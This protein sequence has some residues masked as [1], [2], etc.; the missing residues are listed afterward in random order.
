MQVKVS[1]QV[2]PWGNEGGASPFS[3]AVDQKNLI[4]IFTQRGSGL[5]FF[6]YKYEF[7]DGNIGCSAGAV[8]AIDLK[9]GY[10]IWEW[11]HP[12][13]NLN[14]DCF[15]DCLGDG[16]TDCMDYA[17][18]EF[19]WG[20]C[21][22]GFDGDDMLDAS[23]T[24]INVVYPPK[25]EDGVIYEIRRG[26]MIGPSTI[27]KNMVFIPTM[28]GEIY[29]HSILDGSYIHTIYC[30]EYEFE[31]KDENGQI[32]YTPNREGTRSGQT[33]FDDYLIF[34]CGA[35]FVHPTDKDAT[36]N[37]LLQKGDLVVM[38]LENEYSSD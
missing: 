24:S 26:S 5:D 33:M 30:P 7:S 10:T 38:K 25:N 22:M 8:F 17:H 20:Q 36:D 37:T 21:E 11:V 1:K 32:L 13:M 16:I 31:Y 12:W 2:A 18:F 14:D 28:T 3:L 15:F 35:T 9:T 4:A 23:E 27:N 6:P 29:V 19:D 34:Y